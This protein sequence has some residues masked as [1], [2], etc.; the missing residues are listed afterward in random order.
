MTCLLF[1]KHLDTL[2]AEWNFSLGLYVFEK[3]KNLVTFSSFSVEVVF[4]S[5]FFHTF[6]LRYFFKIHI[7]DFCNY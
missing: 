2:L 7:S 3:L 6:S 1:C 5:Y 4:K